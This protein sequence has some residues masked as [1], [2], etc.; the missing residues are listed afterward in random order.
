MP[1][2]ALMC[3]GE[4]GGGTWELNLRVSQVVKVGEEGIFSRGNNQCKKLG[5]VTS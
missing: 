4:G 2:G 1:S 3:Q 5:G